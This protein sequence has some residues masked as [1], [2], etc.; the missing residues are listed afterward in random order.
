MSFA[1]CCDS[2][3]CW[4]YFLNLSKH[5]YD[6]QGDFYRNNT[7]FFQKEREE[8]IMQKLSFLVKI[9]LTI[10]SFILKTTKSTIEPIR[11]KDWK[12]KR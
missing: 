1:S 12:G 2:F 4:S 10:K 7:I 6:G 5:S 3:S 9:F 11:F 8:S